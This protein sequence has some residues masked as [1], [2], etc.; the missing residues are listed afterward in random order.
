M[1]KKQ[2]KKQWE[3]NTEG[4]G[5]TFDDIADCAVKW[6]ICRH[7]RIKPMTEVVNL[8]LVAAKVKN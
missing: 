5:I 2:F 8:V 7:P 3:S 6:G 1:T 4:G